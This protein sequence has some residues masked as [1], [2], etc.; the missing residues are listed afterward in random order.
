MSD[1]VADPVIA[2]QVSRNRNEAET[3]RQKDKHY[4]KN[5]QLSQRASSAKTHNADPK[6][7]T[8]LE[9]KKMQQRDKHHH[10]QKQSTQSKSIKR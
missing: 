2:T 9:Q 7:S 8:Q 5:R 4:V 3:D 10:V 6:L 1:A